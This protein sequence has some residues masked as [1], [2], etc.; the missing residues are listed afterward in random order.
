MLI[1]CL[2][3]AIFIF[4]I[5]NIVA[6]LLFGVP[7]SLSMTYYLFKEIKEML[8]LLFPSMIILM[9]IFLL[10]CWLQISEGSDFQF[11]AFL[12]MAALMFVGVCP[13]FLDSDL[14]NKVHSISAIIC[15]IFA[16]LWVILVTQFWYI[17]P[18]IFV[19]IAVISV[20][21]KTWK[22][23]YTYWLEMVAFLSTFIAITL[24]YLL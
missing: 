8:K 24:Y 11:S 19:I 18:I 12:S 20:V 2:L 3:K 17:I 4:L 6:L 5:Y 15:A 23:C 21:T 16:L 1:D 10:P 7:H 13:T 9:I 22:T 14:E